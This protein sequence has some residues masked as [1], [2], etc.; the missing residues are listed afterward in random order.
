VLPSYAG[1]MKYMEN[2]SDPTDKYIVEC[3]VKN[4]RK[5]A[6]ARSEVFLADTIKLGK[7]AVPC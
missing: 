2:F 1:A 3:E 6:H 5:K 4:Y 7:E